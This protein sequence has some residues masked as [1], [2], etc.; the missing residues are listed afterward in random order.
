MKISRIQKANN[1]RI[2]RNFSWPTDLPDFA[3]FNVVYGWNGSGKTSLSNLF[4]H[5]QRR[6]ALTDGQ[7]EILVDQ[8]RVAGTDFGTAALPTLRVF[9][10]DAIDRNIFELANQQFPPVFF[11]GED[12]VQKQQKIEDK[13]K[14]LEIKVQSESRWDRKKSDATSA[15]DNFC[16]EEAKGVKNL[17]T[18]AGGGP[19]NNYNAANFKADVQRLAAIT[20]APALLSDELRQQHLATK[21]GKAL[22]KASEPSVSFPDFAGL[23]ARTQALLGHSVVSSVIAELAENPAVA[24]WVHAGLSLHA[25]AGEVAS[26]NCKFCDQPLPERRIRQ[27]EAHFN[28]EFNKFQSNIDALVA[29]I[30]SARGFEQA[31]RVPPKEALYS[32]L[33][34]EY[35][36]TLKALRQ[37][38]TTVQMSLEVLLRALEAKRSEPF[39]DF[40]LRA[41][42]T[43]HSA[44]DE[45]ASRIEAFFQVAMTGLVALSA[46]MGQTAFD[47]LRSIIDQH[48]DR[49]DTFDASV[50]DARAG[51]AKNEILKALP[52]WT[53]RSQA[54]TDAKDKAATARDEAT[55]L[56]KEIEEL[57]V[58]VRQHRRPAEE[59]NQ[60]V[61]SYLG[62][63][64][65]RFEVEQNGYRIMR[66]GQPAMHLSD[67]ERT[68]IAFLYF[69][70]S[71]QGT[72]F[73]LKTGIVVIDDPVS[74]LDANSLFSAFGFMK[75]R[76]ADAGQLFVLTHNFAFFRQVR[77]W[78]YNLPGQRKKDANLQPAR[79]Y[80]LMTEFTNGQRGA[81]LRALDPFL[82]QYESEYH[83]LFKRLHEEAHK[84]VAQ[85]IETYYAIPNIARRL[86]ESFLAF[87]VPDKPGELF[88][89]LEAVQY[90]TAKKT[91]ILRFLHTYSHFDQVAEPDHDLSL[92]SETP[93]ILQEVL[94]LIRKCDPEHFRSMTD[95]ITPSAARTAA[96]DIP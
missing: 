29:D 12:S 49:T 35:E 89:K 25:G 15:F 82:H 77:N 53:K 48:N 59:L 84:P 58:Q 66:G 86:L 64:E 11:L 81:S 2:F 26:S 61:A 32:D 28:D 16:A 75:Q 72:D 39:K 18:V 78:Y 88:Q 93:A 47:K 60:E 1:Y 56:R 4:R 19:Y 31:L 96:A 51:L 62:R 44:S 43:G 74:S 80:M 92:L 36:K 69:L 45:P 3:R 90:D 33:R 37:Q 63:D 46:A 27:L 42:I 67:G 55:K 10:R 41:F 6:Q 14:Q 24:G 13:K 17:L 38:A 94:A 7:I 22:S 21:D 8:T 54:V 23:T 50:K 52:E 68:A 40:E 57:E 87:R 5:I 34:T 76:T 70:K 30:R 9:N 71:L 73:D 91:R 83:Y 65:L 85:G 79:F 20:P 95:L